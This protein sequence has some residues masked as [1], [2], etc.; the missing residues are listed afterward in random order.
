M[1]GSFEA[2]TNTPSGRFLPGL[3][4]MTEYRY[5]E[6]DTCPWS[7]LQRGCPTVS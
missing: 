7:L 5:A 6:F 4:W 1:A 2:A 3:F